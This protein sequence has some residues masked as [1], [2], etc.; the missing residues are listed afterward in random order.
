MITVL[1]SINADMTITVKEIPKVGETLMGKELYQSPGG[2]GANQA[3]AMGK[4]KVDVNFLGKVGED[5]YGDAM[6][7]NQKING[8]DISKIARTSEASTG[9]AMIYV[10]EQANNSIVVVAGA[11]ALV[12]T[13]YVE[14]NQETIEASDILLCQLEVP[15]ESVE[16][17]FEI[18]KQA[19]KI[20]VL[21]PAPAADLSE[22][23]ISLCDIII[24]NETE[25]ERM[26]GVPTSDEVGI[27]KAAKVLLDKGVKELIVTLGSK[28]V[29]WI[30]QSVCEFYA[31]NKVNAVDTTAAGDS[32][33]GGFL[34]EYVKTKD[35][36]AGIKVGQAVAALSVQKQ[37]AQNSLPTY[38]EVQEFL[39]R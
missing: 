38:E 28:G 20:T 27:K 17:G 26:S 23:M 19:G 1:G 9:V 10:D 15:I 21:N 13:A 33:I 18:A 37:G 25:L 2:K 5:A 4:L 35:I 8:V 24:P 39:R 30:N 36:P 14:A 3:V 32:F 12:D 6:L 31:A 16:R 7:E 11:N 34:S 22:K 29:L